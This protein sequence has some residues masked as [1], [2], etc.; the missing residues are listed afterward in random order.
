MRVVI[1]QYDVFY[2]DV[3]KNLNKVKSLFENAN[4]I[5]DDIVVLPE[6]WTSGYDLENIDKHAAKNLAPI[7]DE[8]AY[9]AKK[10]SVNVVAG[11]I[12]NKIEGDVYNTAFYIDKSGEK[13]HQYSKMHLVPMLNEPSF[14]TGGK[15]KAETFNLL[16]EKAGLVICYDLRFPELF[17][18]LV[19]QEAKVIFVVAEWPLARKDHWLTLLRARAIENQCYIV[20]CNAIGTQNNETTF[21]GNSVVYD[22]FGEVL[23]QGATEE[24]EILKAEIDLEYIKEVRKNVPIFNSRRKDM[25]KFL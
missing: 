7:E 3:D 19:L 18:D 1:L 5:E 9:L 13:H 8:I 24:E 11:S 16:G 22:P 15:D 12:P 14:L 10:Y 4:L 6:M 17:R 2:G 23:V 25:Y 20:A 21:A